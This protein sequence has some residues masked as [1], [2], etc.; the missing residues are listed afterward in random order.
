MRSSAA[1][2]VGGSAG[3]FAEEVEF[4]HVALGVDGPEELAVSVEKKAGA[5]EEWAL[6]AERD[7]CLETA[8]VFA[9]VD[10]WPVRRAFPGVAL[11]PV[12]DLTVAGLA[13]Q[14]SW[15]DIAVDAYWAVAYD[16]PEPVIAVVCEEGAAASQD[17]QPARWP[18]EPH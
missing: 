18:Y 8:V 17:S 11:R 4:G 12:V 10:L 14:P 13:E 7:C 2:L 15:R 1:G 5:A 3:G 9:G 16:A 6:A